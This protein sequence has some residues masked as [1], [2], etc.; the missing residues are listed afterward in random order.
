MPATTRLEERLTDGSGVYFDGTLIDSRETPYQKIEIYDTADLGRLMRIDGANMVSEKDEFFYHESLVHPAAIAHPAPKQVLIVG[1]GDGGSAEEVLKHPA[2]ERVVLAE[3]DAG[4]VELAKQYF[5]AVH[6]G[7]FDDARVELRIG[8]G[9]AFMRES[10]QTFDLIYLDLTDPV[11]PAAALYTAAFFADC[12]R[13]L[14]AGGA[15][16][17]HI[18][19]PFA[20]AGRVGQS[21]GQL[22]GLFAN[23]VPWFTYVP[24]YGAT[25]GFAAASDVLD[26]R[27]FTAADVEATLVRRGVSHR[28]YYNGDMHCAMLALPE[29]VRALMR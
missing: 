16:V 20:H 5:Q 8:D 13:A 3:L 4:V 27:P 21:M 7:V 23:V 12:K 15:L 19:S 10:A 18:G 14:N 17:L 26:P 25:W 6:R 29:Y 28:Q 22:R 11:G 2:V 9:L 1:G 24:L